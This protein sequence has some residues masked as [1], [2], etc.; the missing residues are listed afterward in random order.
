MSQ[1]DRPLTI[2]YLCAAVGTNEFTLKQGFRELFGIS[3]HRMLTDIRME[4]AWKL[5]ETGL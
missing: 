4:K 2:A 1:F 3:P 5:L